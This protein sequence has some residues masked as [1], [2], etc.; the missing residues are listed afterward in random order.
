M[1]L[2]TEDRAPLLL[3]GD[4]VD[5]MIV[6]VD[7]PRPGKVLG[8]VAEL[9]M[10]IGILK[11]VK[12]DKVKFLVRSSEDLIDKLKEEA[13]RLGL[14]IYPA[15][16][17]LNHE[18][19]PVF[20]SSG[21]LALVEDGTLAEVNQAFIIQAVEDGSKIAIYGFG[22]GADS[23]D[24]AGGKA[25]TYAQKAALIQSLQL[26]GTATAK[27]L[28]V[29]DTDDEGEPIKGGVRKPVVK[30]TL[31]ALRETLDD[32]DTAEEYADIKPRL[33]ALTPEDQ[34]K[35]RSSILAAKERAGLT[36]PIKKD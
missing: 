13:N 14:L 9:R 30:D 25:G 36:P 29:K 6:T 4:R 1:L 20:T 3:E 21:K 10:T 8:L 23:M 28:G 24:K 2:L 11:K 22:L 31:S 35:L 7:G 32:V 12:K 18:G 27:A 19:V 26:G 16:A 15:P 34:N 17:V 33:L 5:G